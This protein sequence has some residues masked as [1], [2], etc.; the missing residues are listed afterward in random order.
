MTVQQL[1]AQL[2]AL[3]PE[4]TVLLEGDGGLSPLGGVDLMAG[5]GG[6]PDEVVLQPDMTPD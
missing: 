4:A 3:P 5:V 2:A 1:M 6:L